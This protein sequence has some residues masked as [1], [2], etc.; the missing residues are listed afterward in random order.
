MYVCAG[1]A[2]VITAAPTT[3]ANTATFINRANAAQGFVITA[4]VGVY[5]KPGP[6]PLRTAAAPPAFGNMPPCH[7]TLD[8][9]C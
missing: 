6:K 8:H 9:S 7:T 2:P 4:S 3:D 5:A 1:A